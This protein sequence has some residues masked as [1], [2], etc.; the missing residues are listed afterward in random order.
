LRI[1][2]SLYI[3]YLK[4]FYLCSLCF[5]FWYS[6]FVINDILMAWTFEILLLH[7]VIVVFNWYDPSPFNNK[8]SKLISFDAISIIWSWTR[9]KIWN[10]KIEPESKKTTC[11][12]QLFWVP[13]ATLLT[14]GT[15]RSQNQFLV[16]PQI[17]SS[18]T[19]YSKAVRMTMSVHY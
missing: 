16:Q 5:L 14:G 1:F 3:E 7:T 8:S 10:I 15:I 17:S 19:V 2:L 12:S 6:C 4:N 18:S 11:S 13:I 9:T